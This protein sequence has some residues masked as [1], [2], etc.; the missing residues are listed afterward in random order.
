MFIL[1]QSFRDEINHSPHCRRCFAKTKQFSPRRQRAAGVH[2]LIL[3]YTF[4]SHQS[5][6][7]L[8]RARACRRTVSGFGRAGRFR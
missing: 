3:S 7:C 6:F 8:R 5:Q 1:P 2:L 4:W